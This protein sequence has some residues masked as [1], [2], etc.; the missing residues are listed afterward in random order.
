MGIPQDA[1]W[2]IV[3]GKEEREVYQRL[4]TA[5]ASL[6]QARSNHII[7]ELPAADRHV[8]AR[9]IPGGQP[10]N[11][12]W[13][14][15]QGP[16]LREAALREGFNTNALSLTEELVRTW[17]RAGASTGVVWPTNQV[18]QWL[19]KRFVARTTEQWFVMG[20]VYPATNQVETAAWRTC[21][22]D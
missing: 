4:A 10:G 17:A 8:A 11:G 3:S 5:E 6:N 14:G 19:L 2:L 13:L 9:G 1:L 12:R 15:T 20:L 16:L 18:S 22:S 21:R 7:G